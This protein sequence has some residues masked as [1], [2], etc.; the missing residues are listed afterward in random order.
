MITTK[1]N[2]FLFKSNW[3]WETI[4]KRERKWGWLE[5]IVWC[6]TKL[7][8]KIELNILYLFSQANIFSIGLREYVYPYSILPWYVC[9]SQCIIPLIGNFLSQNWNLI[10]LSHHLMEMNTIRID[11][12]E[13]SSTDLCSV[14]NTKNAYG[15]GC[16]IHI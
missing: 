5:F 4:S 6:K 16:L 2:T 11:L 9:K 14:F 8:M 1:S 10:L 12:S 15:V 13:D 7:I 3:I